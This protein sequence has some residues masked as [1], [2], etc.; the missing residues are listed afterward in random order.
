MKTLVI[1]LGS[2]GCKIAKYFSVYSQYE[3]LSID[4]GNNDYENFVEYPK[5]DNHEFY[6]NHE[7]NLEISSG[8]GNVLFITCGA[9]KISGASLRILE[10]LEGN[11]ITVLYIK[12]D[13]DMLTEEAKK[14]ERITFQ[15][16]QQYARSDLLE[17]VVVVDNSMV[18][19]IIP[20]VPL[21]M[22]W[23][24]INETIAST[25]HMI[26]VFSN[27]QPEITT[28]STIP[29]TARIQTIGFSDL[30]KDS[31]V[32]F[33]SLQNQREKL[34]YYAINEDTLENEP[35]LYKKITK[36]VKMKKSKNLRTSFSVYSTKYDLNYVYVL[37][38]ASSIQEENIS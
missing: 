7:P 23:N 33:Y 8:D 3:I 29:E 17:R 9:G 32:L 13:L 15:V 22:Y 34:Y 21:N 24:S 28:F 36:Q 30:E 11:N 1:G 25:F 6:D 12:P 35:G 14:T 18:E 27:T 5:F 31:D 38:A 2:A 26:N 19:K 37:C 10:E 16:L 20:E 4:T